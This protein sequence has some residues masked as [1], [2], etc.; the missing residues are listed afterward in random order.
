MVYSSQRKRYG[1]TWWCCIAILCLP[2]TVVIAQTGS[3]SASIAIDPTDLPSTTTP[4]PLTLTPQPLTPETPTPQ[5]LT[6]EPSTPETTSPAT[7]SPATSSPTPTSP[8]PTSPTPTSPTPTTNTPTITPS[9]PAATT[10]TPGNNSTSAPDPAT[11]SSTSSSGSDANNTS[12]SSSSLGLAEIIGIAVG[13]V[14]L[15]VLLIVF[16]IVQRR[17]HKN[18]SSEVDDIFELPIASKNAQ[19][20]DPDDMENRD[21]SRSTG[22]S[23]PERSQYRVTLSEDPVIL[24]SRI[25][26]DGIELGAIIGRGAFGEVCR[27]RYRGQDV[28]IKALVQE[29]RKDMEYIE[30]FLSEVKLMA[31]MEHPNIVLFIGVA[32]ES[33]SDLCCVIEFLPGGDLRTL[34]KEYHASGMPQG[35]DASK[36]QIAY[37][38]AHAL[39]YLHSLEPVVLHRDLK[40]RNILLTESLTAKITDFGASRIRSDATMT[41]NVGS[42]LWMAPEVMMGERYDEKADI[43]SLGVVISELDTQELPYSHAKEGNSRTGHPLSD[44]AVLQMV[45]MGKLRVHLSPAMHP[46]M[47]QYV[48]RCVSLDPHERP[49]AAEVLYY[50]QVMTRNRQY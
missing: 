26:T 25:S 30:A 42:S 9:P 17:R 49:A 27:G 43:F 46:E 38:V 4:E 29:R 8:T 45:S 7:T 47:V 33:L 16:F 21:T 28:A 44:T 19:L 35:M 41:S 37:G 13:C 40:S 34:L 1:G 15:M 2:F 48:H 12:K 23:M 20:L 18:Q 11:S 24:A 36:L 50:F 32:W 39:T 31:T 10:R 6:P 5:P 22:G 3:G 14:V